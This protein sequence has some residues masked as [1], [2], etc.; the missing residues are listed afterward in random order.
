[1]ALLRQAE[2]KF[3]CKGHQNPFKVRKNLVT[4]AFSLKQMVQ[5]KT[6]L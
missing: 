5:N 1:M 2:Y 4:K 6:L 3:C